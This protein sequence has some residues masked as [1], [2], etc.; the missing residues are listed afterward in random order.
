MPFVRMSSPYPKD[1]PFRFDSTIESPNVSQSLEVARS[2][3]TARC[4]RLSGRQIRRL[5]PAGPQGRWQTQGCLCWP[6]QAI[7]Q[8]TRHLR[9][10]RSVRTG[11]ETR[12]SVSCQMVCS[13]TA[14]CALVGHGGRLGC[15]RPP[16]LLGDLPTIFAPLVY[17]SPTSRGRGS[18]GGMVS[19]AGGL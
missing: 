17:V 5:F 13:S 18:E 16:S 7:T 10:S 14:P 12:L 3:P 1:V 8:Y 19:S 6:T 11:L 9:Q 4:R 15:G 2:T